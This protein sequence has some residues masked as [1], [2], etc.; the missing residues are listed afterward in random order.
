MAGLCYLRYGNAAG[1]LRNAKNKMP[2]G[3]A[4]QARGSRGGFVMTV[5]RRNFAR[6]AAAGSVAVASPAIA[7][8]PAFKWRLASSFPK[9]LEGLWGASPTVARLVNEMS[10]GKFVIDT[11]AAGE[12]VPGL[13]V[14]DAVQQWHDRMRPQL[15]GL[16]RRQEPGA[17]LRR[18]AAVRPHAAPAQCLVLIGDG[19]S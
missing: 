16:L 9:N 18:L 4:P 6:L 2:A 17:D 12:I 8:T 7:Q 14:L 15:F 1:T 10:D 19:R 3:Q 13:Q 11:F 5:S